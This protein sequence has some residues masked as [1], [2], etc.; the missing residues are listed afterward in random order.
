MMDLFSSEA[1]WAGL[2]VLIIG[3]NV[4]SWYAERVR[5]Q[6][7]ADAEG[8]S[9]VKKEW[10]WHLDAANGTSRFVGRGGRAHRI[11]VEDSSQHAYTA[12]IRIGGIFAAL[13]GR[14][15]IVVWEGGSPK[16]PDP[17]GTDNDRAAPGRV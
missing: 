8:V 5:L 4:A 15:P 17:V 11:V 16:K 14:D 6:D 1:L 12:C 9:V 3:G 7:W 10:G 13:L 2:F